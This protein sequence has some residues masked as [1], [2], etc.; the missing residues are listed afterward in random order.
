MKGKEEAF[1]GFRDVLAQE[2][3]KGMPEVKSDVERV[4]QE[5]GGRGSTVDG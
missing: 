4:L 2:M 5:T 3:V 1:A